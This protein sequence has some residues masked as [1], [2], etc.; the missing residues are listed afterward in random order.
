MNALIWGVHF[1]TSD[2]RFWFEYS[3]LPENEVRI[4]GLVRFFASSKWKKLS[5]GKISRNFEEP[6]PFKR[7]PYIFINMLFWDFGGVLLIFPW[8]IYFNL[9]PLYFKSVFFDSFLICVM[10]LAAKG[11]AKGPTSPSAPGFSNALFQGR[12]EWARSVQDKGR[13]TDAVFVSD[14]FSKSARRFQ[15]TEIPWREFYPQSGCLIYCFEMI[16]PR[17]IVAWLIAKRSVHFNQLVSIFH[18]DEGRT[19]AGG[20][21]SAFFPALV[22]LFSTCFKILGKHFF[23]A[24][25]RLF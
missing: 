12:S 18:R 19:T 7:K 3:C 20:E 23:P 15:Y 8:S 6:L 14:F 22:R 25:F 2:D 9:D 16:I 17:S 13:I 10:R 21:R 4:F 1:S 24:Y 5:A 11:Y